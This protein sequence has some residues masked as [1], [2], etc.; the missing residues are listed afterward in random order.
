MPA[1]QLHAGPIHR[2]IE[3]CYAARTEDHGLFPGLVYRSIAH[4][5]EICGKESL[6][7][8]Q[9]RFQIRRS[10]LL[11]PFERKLDVALERK[12]GRANAVNGGHERNDRRLVVSGSASVEP[13]L[14]IKALASRRT[15]DRTA[16]LVYSFVAKRR[17]EWR[18]GPL[19][20]VE[21]LPVI[22]GVEADCSGGARRADFAEHNRIAA[23]D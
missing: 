6:V 20:R 15:C 11:F 18:R 10:R 2:D 4:Q 13:P 21:R 12:A 8:R 7:G 19:L 14:G 1:V 17:L 23:R 16:A 5:P 22:V 3:A 9:S